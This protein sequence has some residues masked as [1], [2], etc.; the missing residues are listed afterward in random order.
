MIGLNFWVV[1]VQ[2]FELDPLIKSQV[3]APAPR[4]TAMP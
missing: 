4:W 2:G 1:G 3:S